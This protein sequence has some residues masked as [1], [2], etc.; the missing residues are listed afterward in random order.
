LPPPEACSFS[1]ALGKLQPPNAIAA[2]KRAM[3]TAKMVAAAKTARLR[4][5][6]R[7]QAIR[8]LPAAR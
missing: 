7:A 8:H 2:R 4:I 3:P 1:I 6:R 5:W